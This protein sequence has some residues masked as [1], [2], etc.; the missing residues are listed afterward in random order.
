MRI[1]I[2]T[3]AVLLLAAGCD[4]PAETPK[5]ETPMPVRVLPVTSGNYR[6]SYEAVA[7][8]KPFRTVELVARVSGFLRE[9]PFREG[10]FVKKGE[11]LYLIE[12]AQYRI[13][14]ENA[15]AQLDMMKA[16]RDNAASEFGRIQQLYGEKIA[17]PD[18]FDS[19]K[20]AKLEAEAAVL[21]AEAELRQAKLNYS[22]TRIT[23]PFDG[24]IGLTSKDVGN[25]LQ[26]PSGTLATL[27][28]IDPVRV[29]F[30]V[31]D[32]FA[33]PKLTAELQQG[34]APELIVRVLQRDGTLYPE[35]GKISF[36]ENRMDPE[37]ASI[38]LQ[39]RFP[40]AARLLVP[41]EFVRV[42]LED[43]A[44]EPVALV[45]PAALHYNQTQTFVYV[46]GPDNRLAVRPV[47]LGARLGNL[48]IAKS[49]L[50][51]GDRA[52]AAGNPLLRPGVPVRVLGEATR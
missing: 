43:P 1:E 24:W 8:V 3:A 15:Q 40:N 35:A 38:R 34:K 7:Q 45:D 37:T 29:E 6:P 49:G 5:S 28:Q 48:F 47:E 30:S 42:R 52:V 41:G 14:Q 27:A 31:S 13:A 22:Y 23:A 26:A 25:Y 44:T 32:A 12:P 20:A 18:R 16:R 33:L 50:K 51:P 21:A 9:R 4:R 36:W 10:S 39:A 46:V 19:A 17:S 2:F 11:L